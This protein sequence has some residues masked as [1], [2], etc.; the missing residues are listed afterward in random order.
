[1]RLLRNLIY[2]FSLC[3][4][5]LVLMMPASCIKD[6]GYLTD[7][8]VRL[9]FSE[10]TVAF[11]TV[12]ATMG[13]T[14]RQVKVYNPYGSPVKVDAVALRGGAMSRFR[15]NVDGDTAMVARNVE[16]GAHDSIFIFVQACINPND[17]TSPYLVEDAIDFY[18]AGDAS[19]TPRQ[20]LTLTAY[21]RNAVYHNPDHLLRVP[22]V[23]ADG[24]PDTIDFPY[25]VIDCDTWDHSRP[26]VIMGYAVVDSDKTL[27]L[28]PGDE[29][30]FGAD[31]YLWVYDGGTLDVHGTQ[32][33]PVLFTSLR[34][35][36]WYDTLP[37]QWGYIWLSSGSKDNYIEW[38]RIDNG[39]AGIV[40]DTNVNSN[41][42][43][44]IRNSVIE[45]H[46]FA[47][48]VGLGA[49]ID[50]DNMLVD[51]CGANLLLL[52]YGGRYL[53]SSSTFANYWRYNS[54]TDA[55]V[56]LNN[57]YFSA[58][59]SL[60]LRDLQQARFDN[61]IIYGTYV[62]ADSVGEL[63]LDIAE[64]AAFNM[65][66]NHCLLKT[67]H[68]DSAAYPGWHLLVNRDPLLVD[69]T[70]HNYHLGEG[71]PAC[72]AG[73]ATALR[74]PTDLDGMARNTPPSIGCYEY[75]AA[76]MSRQGNKP[77]MSQLCT[78]TSQGASTRLRR[79]TRSSTAAGWAICSKYR[80]TPTLK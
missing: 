77:I 44:T 58:D 16:I 1:M 78:T 33:Q 61:C 45:N 57:Y 29:L 59:E 32:G 6:V 67:F 53:F 35:D 40:V 52:R 79:P 70:G 20:S 75:V 25:S 19:G 54:R 50:G 37:G 71:S 27:H 14:T 3:A 36:G 73:D 51:N 26:H 72:A 8:S 63:N 56:R 9:A 12:F 28:Q 23:D 76:A 13:T 62:G 65:T 30:Y 60:I 34:H 41:P 2:V 46:S 55:A 64:G 18:F 17:Q 10:D 69:P 24:R 74:Q 38:A 49:Y 68:I 42:T 43:L 7:A 4:A 31:A 15:I 5:L 48:I 21:G 39:V 11:D 47:G 22:S 80:S 66:L